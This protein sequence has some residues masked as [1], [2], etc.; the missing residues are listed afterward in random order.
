MH[1]VVSVVTSGSPGDLGKI[2][3][4][5][6]DEGI[7]IDAIG[8]G[9]GVLNGTPVGIISMLVTSDEQNSAVGELIGAL[10][11][12]PG[13][14]LVSSAEHPAL[15]LELDDSPGTLADATSLLGGQDIDIMGVISVDVHVGWGI[16][17]LGF[18]DEGVRDTAS[19]LLTNNGFTVLEPH[20]GRE[21]RHEVD[22]IIRAANP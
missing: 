22:A 17:S 4:A 5:L 16:V 12:G 21:R 2:A 3:Q 14:T 10:D 20:G 9:E 13:H 19:D 15:D 1:K 8:G 18:E 11:L 7:N 6:K